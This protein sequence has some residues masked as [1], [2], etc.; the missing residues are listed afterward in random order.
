LIG[1]SDAIACLQVYACDTSDRTLNPTSAGAINAKVWT[2]HCQDAAVNI[3]QV[4]PIAG[5]NM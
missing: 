3:E 1:D 4:C 2:H 5:H